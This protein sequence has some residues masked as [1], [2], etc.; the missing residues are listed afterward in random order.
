M[1]NLMSVHSY[2]L[3]NAA[4]AFSYIMGVLILK[5][6]FNKNLSQAQKLI[7]AR[8]IFTLVI[9]IF[10]FSP[11]VL[12]KLPIKYSNYL[13]FQPVLKHA[14]AHLLSK[15]IKL[16]T[17]ISSLTSISYLPN[18]NMLLTWIIL[19]TILIFAKKY[20]TDLFISKQHC[21]SPV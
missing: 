7:F 13:Q 1:N 19:F 11:F 17:E 21:Y 3:L 14:S 4:I 9:A 16:K 12:E 20:I 18:I 6:P 5:L 2:W 8:K 10:L 15:Q